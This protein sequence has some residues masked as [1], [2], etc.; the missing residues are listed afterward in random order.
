MFIDIQKLNLRKYAA[1]PILAKALFQYIIHVLNSS[2][3]ALELAML[4]AE[5]DLSGGWWWKAMLGFTY[6]RLDMMR[7]AETQLKSSVNAQPMVLSYH[8]LAKVGRT[9][10]AVT[11]ARKRA[12][13]RRT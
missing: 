3:K 5:A 2:N 13:R 10:P 4:A 8:L 7:E 6:Y 11:S 9:P 1:R 12:R